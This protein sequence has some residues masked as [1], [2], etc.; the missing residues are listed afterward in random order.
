MILR[1]S[2]LNN[3]SGSACISDRQGSRVHLLDDLGLVPVV[4]AI[5][6]A[7]ALDASPA[8]VRGQFPEAAEH[9][10][11]DRLLDRLLPDLVL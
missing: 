2:R 7:V 4:H 9:D 11:L 8:Q 10:G 5:A 6:R 1:P 3:K